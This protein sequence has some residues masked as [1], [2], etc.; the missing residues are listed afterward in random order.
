MDLLF[1]VK[2]INWLMLVCKKGIDFFFMLV[3]FQPFKMFFFVLRLGRGL[4]LNLDGT[5]SKVCIIR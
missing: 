1:F 4:V 2:M 5:A 3:L